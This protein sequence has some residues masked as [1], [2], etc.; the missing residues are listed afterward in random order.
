VSSVNQVS[1][2][3]S[4]DIEFQVSVAINGTAHEMEFDSGYKRSLLSESFREENLGTPPLR[5]ST[6][7]FTTFTGHAFRALGELDVK[8]MYEGKVQK[9]TFLVSKG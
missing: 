8:L 9:Y 5:R 2:G 7:V 3:P 4:E 6:Q 1:Q